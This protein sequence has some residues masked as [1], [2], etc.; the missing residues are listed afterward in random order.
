MPIIHGTDVTLSRVRVISAMVIDIFRDQG[1]KR[2][3]EGNLDG[4]TKPD[5]HAQYRRKLLKPFSF[6]RCVGTALHGLR[7][8][9]YLIHIF[10]AAVL[11][12][13]P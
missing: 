10:Y 2:F 8:P 13:M 5:Y 7:V 1:R 3:L 6:N 9:E 11:L 12:P 4:W